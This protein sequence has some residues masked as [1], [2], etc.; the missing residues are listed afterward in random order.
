MIVDDKI[1]DEKL[2]YYI[3]RINK[4]KYEYEINIKKLWVP[5][6]WRHKHW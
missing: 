1:N 5:V 4:N 3:N 2:Q 6:S